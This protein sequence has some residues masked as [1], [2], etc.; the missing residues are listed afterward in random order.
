MFKIVETKRIKK[1]V[2]ELIEYFYSNQSS[3][4]IESHRRFLQLK[5]INQLFFYVEIVAAILLLLRK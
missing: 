4:S 1:I 3:V 5:Q 2:L